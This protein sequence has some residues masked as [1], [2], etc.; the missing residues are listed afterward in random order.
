MWYDYISSYKDSSFFRD[1]N[2]YGGDKCG[3][4]DEGGNANDAEQQPPSGSPDDENSSQNSLSN[5]RTPLPPINSNVPEST[6]LSGTF[7]INVTDFV[8]EDSWWKD[9]A[10]EEGGDPSGNSSP[11]ENDVTVD[12][13][14]PSANKDNASTETDS[15]LTESNLVFRMIG[16][17]DNNIVDIQ[18]PQ[19]GPTGEKP[20]FAVRVYPTI[21]TSGYSPKE[22]GLVSGFVFPPSFPE[23]ASYNIIFRTQNNLTAGGSDFDNIKVAIIGKKLGIE[24][25][26][27]VIFEPSGGSLDNNTTYQF[28]NQFLTNVGYPVSFRFE[29]D[30]NNELDIAQVQIQTTLGVIP[31]LDPEK[32][33]EENVSKRLFQYNLTLNFSVSTEGIDGSSK[34]YT[35]PT[36]LSEYEPSLLK[37]PDLETRTRQLV[38]FFDKYLE[39]VVENSQNN[40]MNFDLAEDKYDDLQAI[41]VEL[42]RIDSENKIL[43][44]A[45]KSSNNSIDLAKVQRLLNTDYY[46]FNENQ[47]N[48]IDNAEKYEDIEDI[49]KEVKDDFMFRR[50]G[51]SELIE[52]STFN[53][54]NP[55]PDELLKQAMYNRD[56]SR[57]AFLKIRAKRRVQVDFGAAN[58][59]L[60]KR[61]LSYLRQPRQIPFNFIVNDFEDK[62]GFHGQMVSSSSF[63]VKVKVDLGSE[64]SQSITLPSFGLMVRE[65][66]DPSSKYFAIVFVQTKIPAEYSI[67]T[68]VRDI[69]GGVPRET[70]S[71]FVG[72][73]I[74]NSTLKIARSEDT[75]KGYFCDKDGDEL[76]IGEAFLALRKASAKSRIDSKSIPG[77]QV[78]RGTSTSNSKEFNV[79]NENVFYGLAFFP[80]PLVTIQAK[81]VPLP[82]APRIFYSRPTFKKV[83]MPQQGENE[84]E[85]TKGFSIVE[86]YNISIFGGNYG[87]GRVINTMTLLPGEE[88]S[89][90]FT[91]YK[92][93]TSTITQSSTVFE[94]VTEETAVELEDEIER[95]QSNESQFE[96]SMAFHTE[97]SGSYSGYGA[98]VSGSVGY[99]TNSSTARQEMARSLTR[100]LQ[101]HAT[102]ASSKRTVEVNST[103]TS[104]VRTGSSSSITR[105]IQNINTS[106]PL[107]FTFRQ[108]NQEYISVL[109][110]VDMKV[111]YIGGGEGSYAESSFPTLSKFIGQ[112]VK[113][114]HVEAV[115]KKIQEKA[116]KVLAINEENEEIPQEVLLQTSTIPASENDNLISKPSPIYSFNK[117]KQST[118]PNVDTEIKVPGYIIATDKNVLR[119]EGVVT[120]TRLGGGIALDN[121]GFK[122][123][124]TDIAEKNAQTDLVSAQTK[125]LQVQEQIIKETQND[126][127]RV[128][129][130]ENINLLEPKYLAHKGFGPEENNR[131]T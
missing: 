119:T 55:Q 51:F 116:G 46:D 56:T 73:S 25:F 72:S 41:V 95:E 10:Q 50:E 37:S 52:G 130:L 101:K 82:L 89:L 109:H 79:L 29:N 15:S 45:T 21:A 61:L 125:L 17:E 57:K 86:F 84:D 69:N 131:E 3:N 23:K 43:T 4:V 71:W 68:F 64:G 5:E 107:T 20:D 34:S 35:G 110:L 9:G 66:L 92:D 26:Q 39:T 111:A 128:K 27:E 53:I 54:E 60:D 6:T 13:N 59:K 81:E 18:K 75:F 14:T 12:T 16:G 24:G 88:T 63:E 80:L 44:E 76:I 123:Q 83:P 108:M 94:E 77:R 100:A 22:I 97:A 122:L 98:T 106:K 1:S 115:L 32:D 114:Q 70:G 112:Y 47:K 126:S 30:S 8:E 124:D 78:G 67:C 62:I 113:S 104:E 58:N 117:K 102:K 65:T 127:T 28:N 2:H 42:E 96:S 48:R 99:E 87:T 90:S 91:S 40:K 120:E 93:L 85:L 74:E 103:E 121:Y 7:F 36:I 33:D 118:V 31:S 129:Y 11:E 19:A 49:V 38:A 105:N